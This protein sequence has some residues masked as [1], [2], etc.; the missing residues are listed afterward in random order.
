MLRQIRYQLIPKLVFQLLVNVL[1]KEHTLIFKV[2]RFVFQ[3]RQFVFHI[4]HNSNWKGGSSSCFNCKVLKPRNA[5]NVRTVYFR[6][7]GQSPSVCNFLEKKYSTV[8]RQ[9]LV[10]QILNE[11]NVVP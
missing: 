5:F 9:M 2:E 6:T 4:V 10:P 1:I 3:I 11:V 7:S 8:L